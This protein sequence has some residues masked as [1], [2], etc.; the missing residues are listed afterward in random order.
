MGCHPQALPLSFETKA[1]AGA[2]GGGKSGGAQVVKTTQGSRAGKNEN[3]GHFNRQSLPLRGVRR[4]L[5]CVYS[6]PPAKFDKKIRDLALVDYGR[7]NNGRGRAYSMGAA[8]DGSQNTPWR[9]IQRG[10]T[11]G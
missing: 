9:A 10:K 6:Y 4:D 8:N 5:S 1:E 7:R 2:V 3:D 11:F